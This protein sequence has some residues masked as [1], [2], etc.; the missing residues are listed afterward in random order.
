MKKAIGYI[1]VSTEEQVLNGV[2]LDN[3]EER[4]NSYCNFKGFELEEV[5]RDEGISGGKNSTRPG[6]LKLLV[7]IESGEIEKLVLYSLERLS[8]DM[9]TLLAL[10]RYI[11]EFDIELHTVEGMIDTSSPD[12]FMNFAMK[13]FL[14][15]MERRQVKYRTKKALEYK[16]SQGYV[17]GKV[18]FGYS[19]KDKELVE[20][21]KEQEVIEIVNNLHQEGKGLTEISRILVSKGI[22][23]RTNKKFAPQQIKRMIDD[24]KD[25]RKN[26]TNKVAD[27]IKSFIVSIA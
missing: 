10:E 12:G 13:A 6:F 20:N 26:K 4:I 1:R 2:S 11:E 22:K 27:K 15:E 19:R 14:G 17:T 21:P 18:P 7:K 16:K 5:I 3:Q 24:Y 9:L 25:V 8:R 23:S